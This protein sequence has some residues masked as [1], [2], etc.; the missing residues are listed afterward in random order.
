MTTPPSAN[1]A[2]LAQMYIWWSLI[3]LFLAVTAICVTLWAF[4]QERDLRGELV[5]VTAARACPQKVIVS[6]KPPIVDEAFVP[7]PPQDQAKS[8]YIGRSGTSIVAAMTLELEALRE[9]R[10][11]GPIEH[12]R[13][14]SQQVLPPRTIHVVNLW[15][16]WCAP[17]LEELPDFKAMFTR[18]PDW[19]DKVRFVPIML[20]DAAAPE[21]AYRDKVMP[22]APYKLA[23]RG[24]NDPLAAILTADEQRTLFKG[25][26]PV[27]LI[28]DCN[29]R[30][31]WAQFDKLQGGQF[32]ELEGYIDRFIDEIDDD[33]PG[34]W[35]SQEWPGNGRCEGDENTEKHHSLADCGPLRKISKSPGDPAVAVSV[36]PPAE[37]LCPEDSVTLPDGRCKPKLR[38]DTKVTPHKQPVMATCG[39][40]ECND[41]EDNTNCCEDCACEAPMVCRQMGAGPKRCLLP[42][43]QKK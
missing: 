34:A 28:L 14:G 32:K 5:Q 10:P 11:E 36:P 27:T 2:A 41:G 3:N 40:G 26:L 1:N 43:L 15:A 21:A 37:P 42:G 39:N 16:T 8:G 13:L 24:F 25:N 33:S 4:V 18:R 7:A 12:L 29:R 35:C 9:G 17:C 38:G 31:R 23:D 20:K 19:G 30:V 6:A 22:T